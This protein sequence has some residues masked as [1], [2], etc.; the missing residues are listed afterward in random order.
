MSLPDLSH[1][2]VSGT[3]IAVHVTPRASR[4]AIILRDGQIRV[5]V[6]TAPESGKATAAAQKL[7]AKAMGVAKSR[8]TLIRGQSARDKLFSV[9]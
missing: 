4:N 3:T 7:L 8:L 6:T 2:A 9:D 5:Q 1:L